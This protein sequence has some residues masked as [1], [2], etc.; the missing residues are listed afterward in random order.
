MALVTPTQ[1]EAEARVVRL[2][3]LLEPPALL[4]LAKRVE[5]EVEVVRQPLEARA[6]R[7]RPQAAA[8]AAAQAERT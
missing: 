3:V 2:R 7:V 5:A 1:L 6:V 8:A 4:L